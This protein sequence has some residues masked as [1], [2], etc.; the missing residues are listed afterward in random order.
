MPDNNYYDNQDHN[1]E[2]YYD[3]EQEYQSEENLQEEEEEKKSKG[4]IVPL[5]IGF[6]V[7]F[8]LLSAFLGYKYLTEKDKVNIVTIEKETIYKERDGF[9][10]DIDAL[11]M[12]YDSLIAVA[13]DNE[14]L[15]SQLQAEKQQVMSLQQQL[16]NAQ[17]RGANTSEINALKS[18]LNGLRQQY[19]SSLAEVAKLKS[20]NQELVMTVDSQT[21]TISAI[22]QEKTILAEENNVLKQDNDTKAQ[23]I[24]VAKKLKAYDVYAEAINIDRGL[25]VKAGTERVTSK[26]KKAD[27]IRI[28]FKLGENKVAN[29]GDKEFYLIVKTPS[30]KLMTGGSETFKSADGQSIPYSSKQNA[31]YEGKEKNMLMYMA[32]KDFSSGVYN[33]EVY[34]DGVSI[35]KS[36]VTLK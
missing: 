28:G 35:G 19:A 16:S 30:G 6:V 15:K 4:I 3:E 11:K 13:G 14:L 26:A 8:G 31:M 7:L 17:A 2:E 22:N 9:K 1:E 36:S 23:I 18:Q 21:T 32:A 27:K 12:E 10:N 25:F 5:L 24:D 33:V 29:H 34:A 20:K